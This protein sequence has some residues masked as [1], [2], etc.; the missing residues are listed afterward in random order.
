[1]I[2]TILF[3]IL[4]LLIVSNPLLAITPEE[5]D[6][7][8]LTLIQEKIDDPWPDPESS[9]PET[10]KWGYPAYA[11]A[12]LYLNQNIQTANDYINAW[13]AEFPVKDSEI[14]EK[15]ADFKLNMFWRM[16]L[17]PI[18]GPRLRADTRDNIED[19]MWRWI[20]KRSKISDAQATTW[21]YHGS[22]NH[23]AM[24]KVGFLL[25]AQTLKGAGTPYGPDRELENGGTLAE[26][27]NAWS[28]YFIRY[29]SDRA[30]EGINAE[31]ACPSYAK[32]TMGV[33]HNILDFAESPDLRERAER[34]IHL[35]WADT[36]SDWVLSGERGG[37]ETRCYKDNN[38]RTGDSYSFRNILYAYGWKNES[39]KTHP[40][41]L[42]LL[43][44]TYQMP[45]IITA[46]ATDNNRPNYLYTSRRWGL[47][48]VG[49]VDGVNYAA[50]DNGD[51]H[52]LRETWVTP[53]YA[54]GSLT[55]DMNRDYLLIIDQNRAMGVM[56][57]TGTDDRVMVFGKGASNNDK[58]YAD[59]NGVTRE[60][61]MIVQRDK[62]ANSD[63]NGTLIFVPTTLWENRIETNGW[64]FLEAGNAYC[65]I[66]PS[67]SGYSAISSARG[68]DL[69]LDD[70]WAPVII[71]TGQASK[72]ND[73][74]D[75]QT[76]VLSNTL[77]YTSGTMNYTS[78]AGDRFTL[79]ANSKTTPMVNG[80]TVNL[81]P[82]KT[83]DSPY[84]SMVHGEDIATIRYSG[85]PDLKL[86]FGRDPEVIDLRPSDDA[87]N[88]TFNNSLVITFSEPVQAGSGN[89]TLKKMSDGSTVEVFNV[90]QS[91]RIN[92]NSAQVTI[93]PTVQLEPLTQYYI[94]IDATA[95]E[96]RSNNTFAGF[97]ENVSWN[98]A[99]VS[100]SKI[101]LVNTA[102]KV[103]SSKLNNTTATF[104][105]DAGITADMLIVALSSEKS[106]G[107]YT[108]SY[109]GHNLSEAILLGQA[110]IWYL[111]LN[112]TPYAGGIADL[113]IDYTGLETV[114]GVGIG[115]V[116][117]DS[118]GEPIQLHSTGSGP[119]D[120]NN[121]A[122]LT[123]NRD[124]TFVVACFNANDTGSPTVNAP[125]TS[126]YE[127]GNTGSA[128]GASGYENEV[129]AGEHTY[130]WTTG[131]TRKVAAASF[132]IHNFVNWISNYNVNEKDS[133]SEDPDK[134]Q[135][136]NG[137][138]ALLGTHPGEASSQLSALQAGGGDFTLTHPRNDSP[139]MDLQLG[140][141]WSK[142]LIKWYDCDGTNGPPN[143]ETVSV[144]SE[145][146]LNTATVTATISNPV[147][148]L[149]LRLT[150]EQK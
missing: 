65:A 102:S 87:T 15:N 69:E 137:I 49:K 92:F 13:Y 2:K 141:Q 67:N 107:N 138:E 4:S 27:A 150:A 135:V 123:T 62:N 76:S 78:E 35:Y 50:F 11:L 96:D 53:D 31:I 112:K 86:D 131:T 19:M 132:A 5:V 94:T 36:A 114:N 139:P 80:A 146:L 16:Y 25:C 106:Q 103:I 77:T 44:S 26:H 95:V 1:M 113:V 41:I 118:G 17:H 136:P 45:E 134:D 79:Y 89:I 104:S 51:S 55:F 6:A 149:F 61:C 74:T 88:V 59:L 18:M 127:S 34:F 73:F 143:G 128:H 142:D 20:N 124:D 47:T 12:A 111:D 120:F 33:Y 66:K 121:S 71:Q 109:D 130:S 52:L 72:Y 129:I 97:S 110:D 40:V 56:F 91:D 39:T 10:R 54:M 90:T 85:Y 63:G 24:Q 57:A 117:I 3:L 28:D 83:Y 122:T 38:V 116:S 30:Q 23:D 100:K 140:Y 21:N 60:D 148:S 8:K 68:Y 98:F 32:Y 37:G 64:L 105:F 70:M 81:N 48:I 14:I 101:V 147:D 126:I 84:L 29:F 82:S 58:S 42:H 22:E 145:S 43:T 133:L 75:F 7:R 93:R 99:T 9:D 108:V 119:D 144:T 46:I 115:A 125:L